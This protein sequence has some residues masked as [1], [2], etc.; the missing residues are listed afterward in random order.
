[1]RLLPLLRSKRYGKQDTSTDPCGGPGGCC[2]RAWPRAREVCCVCVSVGVT[3]CR[4][5][6]IYEGR[7]PYIYSGQVWFCC[8]TF[9]T[10]QTLLYGK[11]DTST[12]PVA[13]PGGTGVD[14]RL[15]P[16]RREQKPQARRYRAAASEASSLW[17][18]R[19]IKRVL[20]TTSWDGA[21]AAEP[22]FRVASLDFHHVDEFSGGNIPAHFLSSSKTGVKG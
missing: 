18:F 7:E 10:E 12:D 2:S 17:L 8:C 22:G 3:V 19:A 1:M 9:I 11:Q 13:G 16:I 20:L 6:H 14:G 21:G 15:R 5:G 4:P